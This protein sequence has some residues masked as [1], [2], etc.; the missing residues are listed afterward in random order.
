[1]TGALTLLDMAQVVGPK[2]ELFRDIVDIYR[3]SSHFTE[4]GLW[5]ESNAFGKN[6][7]PQW[8]TETQGESRWANRG[9]PMSK[10]S[11]GIVEDSIGFFEDASIVDNFIMRRV[12]AGKKQQFRQM[13]DLAH[14]R[15]MIKQHRTLSVYGNPGTDPNQPN[16]L[17]TRRGTLATTGVLNAAHSITSKRTSLMVMAWD[18]VN[19]VANIYP[20]GSMIGLEQEDYGKQ[21]ILDPDNTDVNRLLPLWITWFTFDYGITVADDAALFRICNINPDSTTAADYVKVYN[22]LNEA[23][24]SSNFDPSQLKIY[25]NTDGLRFMD[26]MANYV[27][28]LRYGRLE[29]EGKTFSSSF[30]GMPLRLLE[31]ISSSETAVS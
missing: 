16:G 4:D 8:S 9:V 15:G 13:Y 3:T 24:R 21:I 6:L 1:M 2:G 14:T 30:N 17:F 20:E 26:N 10:G 5:M 7:T 27:T 22:L 19:G 12:P 11:I 23:A 25:G 18:S 31:E 29:M 28:N